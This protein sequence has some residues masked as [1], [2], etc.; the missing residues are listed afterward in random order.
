[1]DRLLHHEVEGRVDGLVKGVEGLENQQ[2]EL[3]VKLVI[4]MVKEVTKGD[5]RSVNMG[6]GRNGCSYKDFMVC[7]P[8]D[9]DG[10]GGA[11][12]YT[13]WIEKMESVK[14]MSGYGANQKV[15]YTAGLFIDKALTWWNTQ[16]QTREAR[17]R[18]LV[19]RDSHAANNDRFHKLSWLVPYLVTPE[20]KRIERYIYGLAPQIRTMVATTEPTKIQSVVLKVRM[21][22][23]EAIR[24]GSLKKNTKKGGNIRELSIKENV[25]DDNKRSKTGRVFATITNPIRKEYTSTAPK[26]CRARPMI[27]THV[28]ARNPTTA[29][30]AYFECG[31]IDHYKAACPSFVS[32]TFIPLLDIEPSDLGFSYEIK[33]ASGQVVKINK[34][35]RD[36]KLEIE[37]HT[38]DINLIPFGHGSFDVIVGID[39]LSRHKDEICCHEVVVRTPLPYGKILRVLG[40]IPEEKV[41][42]LMSA[43][44]EEPKLRDIVIVRKFH[45]IDLRS[46]YHQLRVHKDDIPK[47]AFR[48]RYGHFEFTVALWIKE[49]TSGRARDASRINLRD[50][51]EGELYAKFSRCEFW[52]QEVQFLRHVINGEGIHVDPNKIEVVTN[53][54]ALRTP[55]KGK[56]QEEA[57]LI[58]KDKLCNAPILVLPDGPKDFIVYCDASGK[59]NVIADALSRNERIKPRRVRAMNMTIQSSIKDR[60]L[61]AQNKASEVV[62][63]L[64]EMLRGLD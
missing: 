28:C 49:C 42:Y 17:N 14:D 48:T 51:Q 58:L 10:K 38:F 15:K 19:S 8:K 45:E 54:E 31:G 39:W 64:T 57:F 63:A 7:N 59:V 47:T 50:A 53:W 6:N 20:N 34:V 21:L 40:E 11:I 37:G 2:A 26:D 52:L 23:D 41:R 4:E 46:G 44:N 12:V 33:I 62:D 3:V 60:I 5:V 24:N 61:V 56:E 16:V 32:T 13:R 27:V 18:V 36:C 25:R 55:S 9:Y 35:I 30:G 22:T 29:R 43:K 1:V